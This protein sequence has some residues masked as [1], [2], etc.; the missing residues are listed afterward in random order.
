MAIA[1]ILHRISGILI[2]ILIPVMLWMFAKSLHSEET[3]AQ[4]SALIEQPAYK[5]ILWA[6]ASAMFYHVL[7][8][9]RHMIMDVGFGEHL[10][11]SRKSA[12]FVI[13][14]GVIATIF[15]GIWIC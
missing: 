4:L 6:F 2:F 11:A 3:F 5:I 8:G 12:T 1:S 7:A 9:I 15:L 10:G 13:A 14:L